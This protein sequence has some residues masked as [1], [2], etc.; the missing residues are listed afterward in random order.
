[1]NL[2]NIYINYI[3]ETK[4]KLL[5]LSLLNIIIIFILIYNLFNVIFIT[6]IIFTFILFYWIID[7][8]V[9]I[10]MKSKQFISYFIESYEEN[11]LI[12]TILHYCDCIKACSENIY[13]NIY[14]LNFYIIVKYF[15]MPIEYLY[16]KLDVVK[17]PTI[18]KFID[19][20]LILI[21]TK[22][23]LYINSFFMKF[24]LKFILKKILN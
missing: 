1:M 20:Y 9:D 22:L 7:I 16:L 10:H 6:L 5:N 12:Y 21:I 23:F 19:K 24:Y 13:F 4:E 15:M 2:I 11:T 3:D 17:I 18:I 14:I 8:S